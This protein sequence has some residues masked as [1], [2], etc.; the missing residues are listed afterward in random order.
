MFYILKKQLIFFDKLPFYLI[1]K[2]KQILI[3]KL[4][5][6]NGNKLEIKIFS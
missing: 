4:F 3:E 6:K 2:I 5:Q 1:F